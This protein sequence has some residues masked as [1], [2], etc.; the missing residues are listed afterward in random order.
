MVLSRRRSGA[1]VALRWLDAEARYVCGAV[2]MPRQTLPRGWRWMAPAFARLA[3]R[4]ISAGT[5][6]DAAL[7]ARAATASTSGE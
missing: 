2:A 4:W 1:C 3:R 5:G 7:D 6:C